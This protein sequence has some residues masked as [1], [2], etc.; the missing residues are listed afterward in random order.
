MYLSL[1]HIFLMINSPATTQKAS[2]VR[3][4]RLSHRQNM[5]RLTFQNIRSV[6]IDPFT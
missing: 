6:N 4:F 1:S 3:G 5:K 2:A